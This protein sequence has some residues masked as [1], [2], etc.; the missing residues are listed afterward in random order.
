MI[1]TVTNLMGTEALGHENNIVKKEA[2]FTP[3]LTATI[4]LHQAGLIPSVGVQIFQDVSKH[5]SSKI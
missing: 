3:I 5:H 1:L 2:Q 4:P